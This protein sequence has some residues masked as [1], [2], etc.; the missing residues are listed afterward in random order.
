MLNNEEQC[1][2]A[3]LGADRNLM[4]SSE[5]ESS[6][7]HSEY[8]PIYDRPADQH[9]DVPQAEVEEL[10][11]EQPVDDIVIDA[12]NFSSYFFDVRM[13]KP[14][15]GQVMARFR[16]RAEFVDGQ[17][18]RDMIDL[19]LNNE[20]GGD[21]AKTVMKKLACAIERDAI[22]V[23]L[24]ITSDLATGMSIEAVCHKPYE[25]DIECF[26]YTDP[27]NVPKDD[28]HWEI[29]KI[30]G[31]PTNEGWTVTS[32]ISEKL[33]EL[34]LHTESECT[35]SEEDEYGLPRR[36]RTLGEEVGCCSGEVGSGST[37]ESAEG[38]STTT[39]EG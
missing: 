3:S 27:T 13:N 20:K 4:I 28:K 30:I 21:V 6:S 39:T 33:K 36:N 17:L 7:K 25:Y 18:K 24:Q 12:S 26:Y 32:N 37:T 5:N 35:S 9:I 29:I 16:G 2:F 11:K 1:G 14:V 8:T 15:D 23:P 38:T 10:K 31:K 22:R 19:L 34:D